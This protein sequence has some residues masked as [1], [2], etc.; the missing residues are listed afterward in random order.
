MCI[1]AML[2]LDKTSG[3]RISSKTYLVGFLS[4]CLSPLKVNDS[5]VMVLIKIFEMF[6]TLEFV[7]AD[8]A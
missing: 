7:V 1:I 8:T 6:S 2:A 4:R 3:F 5:I